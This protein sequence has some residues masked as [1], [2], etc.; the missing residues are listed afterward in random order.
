MKG[1]FTAILLL[2]ATSAHAQQPSAWGAAHFD[3]TGYWMPII[4][5]DWRTRMTT[6]PP[7]DGRRPAKPRPCCCFSQEATE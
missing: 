4:T 3:L 6:A 1:L 2:A 5:E 7:G